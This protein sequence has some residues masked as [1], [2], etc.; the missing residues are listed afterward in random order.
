MK[1][2]IQQ[3]SFSKFLVV[4]IDLVPFSS[5]R[6]NFNAPIIQHLNDFPIFVD[7][8][9]I[10]IAVHGRINILGPRARTSGGL[11]LFHYD[12]ITNF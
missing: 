7:A 4:R 10:G 5:S 2:T 11:E 12:E 6:L 1:K 9:G 3:V 8:I